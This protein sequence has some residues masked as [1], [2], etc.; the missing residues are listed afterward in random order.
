MAKSIQEFHKTLAKTPI[1]AESS[2]Y[3]TD[4][5]WEHF[6]GILH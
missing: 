1:F 6:L 2:L 3:K 5:I 4:F